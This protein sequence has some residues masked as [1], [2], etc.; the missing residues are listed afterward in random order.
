MTVKGSGSRGSAKPILR[1][2]EGNEEEDMASVY[3]RKAF[4]WEEVAKN[5]QAS[6]VDRWLRD[7]VKPE[8]CDHIAVVFPQ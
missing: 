3:K 4:L 5:E 7:Q 8:R 2:P 6:L 1:L